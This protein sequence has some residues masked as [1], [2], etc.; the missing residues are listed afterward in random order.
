MD[1]NKSKPKIL[2]ITPFF[3]P[4]VKGGGPIRSIEGIIY[5]LNSYFDFYVYTPS[6][7]FGD[8]K[9]YKGIP[10]NQWIKRDTYDVYYA[11]KNEGLLRIR[12]LINNLKPETIYLNSFFHINYSLK[13]ILMSKAKL[14]KCPITLAPRGEFSEGALNIKKNKKMIF[15]RLTKIL[16]L[17]DKV[18]WHAS[19]QH[20]KND[21]KQHFKNAGVKIALNLSKPA[22][23]QIYQDKKQDGRLR[24]VFISRISN[25]KNLYFALKVLQAID[26]NIDFDVYGPIE[27]KSYW[28]DCERL[29]GQLPKNINV[30]YK[31]LLENN[32][33]IET[34]SKYDFLFFPTKGENY[35]HVIRESLSA[36]TPVIISD[37]TPW[38]DLENNNV[39]FVVEGFEIDSYVKIIRRINELQQ[40]ELKSM[41]EDCIEYINRILFDKSNI[42][43]NIELFIR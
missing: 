11:D 27:D 26:L 36:G 32:L 41:S 42:Q 31:G 24:L 23:N 40:E 20:E 8:N 7:D 17:Y 9:A 29:I 14:I 43:R 22:K 37:K 4:G 35:G 15:I 13:F 33:V 12:K 34:L 5:H 39:G 30:E 10:K 16:G 21:I 2:I 38:T 1:F 25:K 28:V 6:K 18:S 3:T 19:S